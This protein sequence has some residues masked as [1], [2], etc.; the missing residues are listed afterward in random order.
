MN[1][2]SFRTLHLGLHLGLQEIRA[3]EQTGTD[4][5]LVTV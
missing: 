5:V 1:G 3:F 2:N 4:T